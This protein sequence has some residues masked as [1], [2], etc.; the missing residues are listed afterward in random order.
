M[1]TKA[2]DKMADQTRLYPV[3]C[4]MGHQTQEELLLY[5]SR[6]DI[7]VWAAQTHQ[8]FRHLINLVLSDKWESFK[9][10]EKTL[11]LQNL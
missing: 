11:E 6:K 8:A 4:G 10:N 1:Q 9:I 2:C 3:Q 5:L 7:K